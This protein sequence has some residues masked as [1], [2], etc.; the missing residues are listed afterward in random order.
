MQLVAMNLAALRSTGLDLVASENC[1]R[2]V[3]IGKSLTANGSLQRPAPPPMA[4]PCGVPLQASEGVA[5][6]AALAPEVSVPQSK[7][8]IDSVWSQYCSIENCN[9]GEHLER[10]RAVAHA[11]GEGCEWIASEKVHGA[12]FCFETDGH[13]VEYASRTCRLGKGADFYNARA[14][15]P[16]YHP[17]VLKA[18]YLAKQRHSAL[19]H[20]L[21][22]GEYFGGYYPGHRAEPGLKK[23]QGGVAYSPGHHFYAFDVSLDGAGYMD[24]DNARELLMAAGFPLVAAPLRRGS[25]DHVLSI[26]VEALETSLPAQL[27]HPPLDRFRVAEGVVIRPAQELCLGNHKRAILKKKAQA[28]WEATNQA[29]TL[30][31]QASAP[32]DCTAVG[33]EGMIEAARHCVTYNRLRTVISKDPSLLQKGQDHKLAG[34]FARDVLNEL[35][36]HHA[37]GMKT[38]GKDE[39]AVRKALQFLTRAF[40]EKHGPGIREDVG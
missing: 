28:F 6:Q 18:F 4:P 3:R 39:A 21:V 40:V 2:L 13:C 10:V 12:N 30:Y 32:L 27:G 5:A 15:M 31:R 7:P 36:K 9:H 11:E 37:Q 23:V 38:L 16:R 24:F 35:E 14:T 29:G 33:V 8:K 22:Y 25:L 26:D 1:V 19:M 34:L 17:H 20:L